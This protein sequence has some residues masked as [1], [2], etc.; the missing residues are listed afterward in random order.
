MS[1]VDAFLEL[2]IKQE[3][4][5]LH[6]VSGNPPR[7]RLYGEI[8]PVKYR[9]LTEDETKD[10]LFEIMP[11]RVRTNFETKGG[12]DFG[13]EL[14]GESRFRVNAFR[15][16]DGIGA[17]F[18]A[19]PEKV[20]SLDELQMPAILKSLSR[21]RKG[22]VLVSGPTG[23]GKSTTLA[24][25]ID[26]INN[27]RKGHIIT[28]EDPVEH[29]HQ[30]KGCLI[31][32]REVGN[33]TDSFASALRSALR[34]DPDVILV[35]ELRDLETI[36][37]AV[38]A[39]EMGILILATLH[40]NGAA[41]AIDRVINVF[42]PGEEPYIRSMLSTSLCGVISQQLVKT[43]DNRGR[44]AA[45]ETLINNSATSNIIREGKTEQLESV[46]Q[47]SALQGMQSIDMALRRLLDEKLITGEE[48]YRKARLKTNFEQYREQ[49]EPIDTPVSTFQ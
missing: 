1:R 30:H 7:I 4:S 39:A 47:G 38:T 41:A 43:A 12:A 8:H 16:I 45:V 2:L 15:H 29:V 10:L 21:Q 46:I 40:T 25:M 13:Y 28:I 49:D 27:E 37:L 14:P 19:I 33:H 24:A 18:R 31:S 20:M 48:A 22:L 6:L 11:D 32:Q 34:E 9:E 26:F 36:S 23:S 3:G 17:V 5:D 42:P 44:L 35:G